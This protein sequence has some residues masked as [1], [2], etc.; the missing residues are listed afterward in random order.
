S[1]SSF[2]PANLHAQSPLHADDPVPAR[3]YSLTDDITDGF[4]ES[5]G[6]YD[7]WLN[8]SLDKPALIQAEKDI[9]N[10]SFQGQ[11]LRDADITRILAGRDIYDTQLPGVVGLFT[12]IP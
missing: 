10:L 12:P 3:I 5:S 1:S 6:L 2:G 4:L 7:K 9:I 11:N 8:I